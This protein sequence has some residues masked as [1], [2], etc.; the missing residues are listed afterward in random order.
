MPDSPPRHVAQP[1][2][3][4][5][6][7]ERWNAE[8]TLQEKIPKVHYQSCA[9]TNNNCTRDVGC[10]NAHEYPQYRR[11]CLGCVCKAP[12]RLVRVDSK[13]CPATPLTRRRDW[14]DSPGT[15]P[16]GSA[17]AWTR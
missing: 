2:S 13:P 6:V 3:E 12:S 14:L 5:T 9:N 8:R 11:C 1:T 4:Q 7:A 15:Q 17:H 16:Y 10:F